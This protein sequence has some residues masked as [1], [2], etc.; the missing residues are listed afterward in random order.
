MKITHS[1]SDI[2]QWFFQTLKTLL[3]IK[4][5]VTVG[6]AGGTSCDNWYA[7]LLESDKWSSI[8]TSR[9]RWCVTDERMNCNISDR[10]DA[11]IWE[12]FLN[13]LFQKY[14]LPEEN[15]VRPPQNPP[16]AILLSHHIS[17][18][19]NVAIPFTFYPLPSTS[20]IDIAFFGMGPD[21]H[22][23]SLFPNHVWLQSEEL[24]FIK[25]ENAPKPPPERISLSPKSIQSLTHTCLFVVW[26]QK[27]EALAN[28]L[29]DSVSVVDCPVK[30]LKPEILLDLTD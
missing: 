12:V 16:S 25:I 29:D 28:F 11:H 9:I 27:K 17:Q 1:T 4:S 15:F 5:I 20:H 10:N 26:S 6:L 7:E 21:G 8:G 3:E 13:P 14:W 23:A 22:T 2:T 19:G 30:L 18:G 24:W